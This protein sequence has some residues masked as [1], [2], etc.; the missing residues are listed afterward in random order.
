MKK[1]EVPELERIAKKVRLNALEMI[2][3][4]GTGHLGSAMST[5]ELLTSLYF[6]GVLKFDP[7][8]PDWSE[9][10]YFLLSNGHACPAFY[11]VLARAGYFSL[12]K[13]KNSLFKLGTG[14]EGHPIKKSLPGIEISSGSLG[15]GLAVGLGVA[16]GLRLEKKKNRVIVMMSD[17][18]QQEGSVWEAVMAIN[19][20]QLNNLVAIIDRNGIQIAGRTEDN[21]KLEP[22]AKKYQSFGW[23]VIK[24]DGH[25]FSQ[26]LVA[27]DQA[28][29][30]QKPTVII[31]KTI[32]AKGV[33]HLEG[34]EDT[35]HPKL[36]QE[37]YQ[38]TLEKFKLK[39]WKVF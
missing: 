8:N 21:I 36:T 2:Y 7:K 4:A 20:Y 13:L 6:G 35:H 27:F 18:E 15:M 3:E 14:L 11:A 1:A 17:G 29:Q 24:I 16:L 5:V 23:Q 25:N 31:A 34:R 26:I 32:P 39:K 38:K 37:I 19:H 10:D 12:T 22:L 30:N 33:Y 9:R 28:W